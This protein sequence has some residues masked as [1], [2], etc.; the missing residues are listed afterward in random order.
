M[1]GDENHKIFFDDENR[2]QLF[3]N[4]THSFRV[5][6]DFKNGPG[7]NWFSLIYT[8]PVDYSV[9]YI[10][11]IYIYYI[12]TIYIYIHLKGKTQRDLRP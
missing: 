4:F 6:Y 8:L 9:Y 11:T 12:Y 10:Y 3:Y 7:F 5:V 1:I 2:R